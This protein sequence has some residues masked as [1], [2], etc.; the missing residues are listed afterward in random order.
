[1]PCR[2]A[3]RFGVLYPCRST[4][5]LPWAAAVE[6]L[7]L[8]R[9]LVSARYRLGRGRSVPVNRTSDAACDDSL[10]SVEHEAEG[11]LGRRHV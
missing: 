8:K 2:N 3:P 11:G 9:L 5:L 6:S 1:M 4:T 7:P 10:T